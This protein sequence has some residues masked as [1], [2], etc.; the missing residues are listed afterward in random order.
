MMKILSPFFIKIKK[1]FYSIKKALRLRKF[2]F[3]KKE[4]RRIQDFF[5]PAAARRVYIL[6]ILYTS[7][8]KKWRQ[9]KSGDK[10]KK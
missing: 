9:E 1:E 10:R 2:G 5:D 7:D 4:G 8:G 6:L 3:Q